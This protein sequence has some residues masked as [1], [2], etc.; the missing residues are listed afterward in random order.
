MFKPFQPP[1]RKSAAQ[2]DPADLIV[3]PESD[4]DEEGEE[5][6]PHRPYK[7]RKLL[8]HDVDKS[9]PTPKIAVSAAALA[10]RKPLLPVKNSVELKASEEDS[11]ESEGYYTVLW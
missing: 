5:E 10:P 6:K 2:P 3:I 1:L 9:P 11:E 4:D 8:V 7:K